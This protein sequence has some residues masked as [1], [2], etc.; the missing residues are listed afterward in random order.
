VTTG[1][2]ID[3]VVRVM[4]AMAEG[5]LTLRIDKAYAGAYGRMKEYVNNTVAK[6]S[7][8]VSEVNGSAEAL[9]RYGPG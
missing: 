6:L 5:D 8:V 4:G 3:E 7:Q 2:S 1:A 9:M